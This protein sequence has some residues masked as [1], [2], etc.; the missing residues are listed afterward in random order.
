MTL[1]PIWNET[2][3]VKPYQSDF[4]GRWKPHCFFQAMQTAATHHANQLGLGYHAMME[5]ETV[6]LLARLKL[7]IWRN[8]VVGE[9]VKVQTWPR[10]LQQKIFFMRDFFLFDEQEEK[11]AAATSAW[12][13][14]HAGERR[15]LKPDP[16]TLA[17][18]P[19]NRG[20][21]ALE[22]RL[23]KIH[24][25]DPMTSQFNLRARYADIDLMQHVNNT[26]YI[27]WA[28]DCFDMETHRT[29]QVQSIQINY[30]SEVKPGDEVLVR[31]GTGQD[32]AHTISGENQ[33]TGARAFEVVWRW[34][35]K[36]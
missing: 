30:A 6:W 15:I 11:I 7:H 29:R 8:P 10:G 23:D 34:K 19:D 36:E 27:E 22:E 17:G 21:L 33:T 13:L 5:R 20:R 18:L 31:L 12:L 9:T 16:V 4:L 1:Q 28:S 2:T 32:G 25:P 24:L 3:T 14:V 26:R 35:E